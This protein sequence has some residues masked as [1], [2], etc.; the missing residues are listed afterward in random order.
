MIFKVIKYYKLLSVILYRVNILLLISNPPLKVLYHYCLDYQEK[1]LYTT[2]NCCLF[3]F[4]A[5]SNI[6]YFYNS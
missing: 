6:L 5:S 4:C 3:N 2:I 1:E